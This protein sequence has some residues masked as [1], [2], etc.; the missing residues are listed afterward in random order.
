MY[1]YRLKVF[2]AVATSGSFSR[3]ARE[4]LH[5]SQPAVS[6][7]VQALEMELG[8]MLVQRVGKHLRLTEAGRLVQQ[9][10]EQVL[11][12]AHDTRKSR[13][14]SIRQIRRGA[15]SSGLWPELS[16]PMLPILTIWKCWAGQW[17]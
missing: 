17:S 8:M 1:S 14:T 5:I 3:A 9:Y 6:Q 15:T 7:H 11:G 4:I 12:L 13:P 16:S 10:A 2:H